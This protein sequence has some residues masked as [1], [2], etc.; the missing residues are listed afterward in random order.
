MFVYRETTKADG[1]KKVCLECSSSAQ[2]V[3]GQRTYAEKVVDDAVDEMHTW[4]P[5]AYRIDKS[6]PLLLLMVVVVEASA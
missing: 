3:E 1:Q 2:V 5:L 6:Q 4:Q